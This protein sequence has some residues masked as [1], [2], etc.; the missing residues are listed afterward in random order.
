M[1]VVELESELSHRKSPGRNRKER[2]SETRFDPRD[3]KKKKTLKLTSSQ[4]LRLPIRNR[5]QEHVL[6]H[7]R[8]RRSRQIPPK[9]SRVLVILSGSSV[10]NHSRLSDG[11][12]SGAVGGASEA[13]EGRKREKERERGE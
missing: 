13:L 8:G 7:E 6:L 3:S 1:K 5:K 12:E 10:L 11:P 2:S 4:R 9:D